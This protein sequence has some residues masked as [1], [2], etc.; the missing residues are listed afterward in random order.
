M[1]FRHRTDDPPDY[2]IMS[3]GNAFDVQNWRGALREWNPLKSF[4]SFDEAVA[5]VGHL[6]QNAAREDPW[7]VVWEG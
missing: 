4:R 1:K 7:H 5:Y 6:K 2:R 3:D